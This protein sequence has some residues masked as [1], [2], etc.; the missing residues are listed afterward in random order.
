MH[1][2]DLAALRSFHGCSLGLDRWRVT[3][4]VWG[5]GSLLI[6]PDGEWGARAFVPNGVLALTR[7]DSRQLS[8]AGWRVLTWP[9]A[10]GPSA[11]QRRPPADVETIDV[12]EAAV[13]VSFYAA[14]F[15]PWLQDRV[16]AEL[17]H[18]DVLLWHGDEDGEELIDVA[19][20]H[21]R[22]LDDGRRAFGEAWA[23]DVQREHERL[24]LPAG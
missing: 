17:R 1:T 18:L 19:H 20:A 21:D 14:R 12:L 16:R 15:T 23:A 9:L 5:P 7:Q 3:A 10:D 24:S 11:V 13:H 8:R 2:E 6:G 4:S 22:L